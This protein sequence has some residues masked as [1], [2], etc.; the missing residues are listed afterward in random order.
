[1]TPR[2]R[3]TKDLVR[4]R[5]TH[6]A[7]YSPAAYARLV[8]AVVET[9]EL[10][11]RFGSTVALD[12]LTLTVEPGEVFGFLGPNGAGKTTTVRLLL[13]IIRATSGSVRVF[14]AD[15]WR[16]AVEIHRR[17]AYVPGEI[18]L[19][20][21]LTGAEILELLGSLHGGVDRNYRDELC[22]R[23]AL[24]PTKKSR[25]YSKGN[26]QKV[27][28]VA[29]LMTRADLLVLDEPTSGLDP[30]MEIAFREC[31]AEATARG[32]TVFLSSHILSEVE[33]LA[34]RV[35][36]LRSG[37]L[38]DLGTLAQLR[39]LRARRV[40]IRFDGAVPD[41]ALVPGVTTVARN[42]GT[43]DVEVQGSMAPL[44]Q[45]IAAY[46]VVGLDSREPSLEEIFVA[47]YGAERDSNAA[48]GSL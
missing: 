9:R 19:W 43:V 21:Q 15:A 30:L 39:H 1:M 48:N 24:D 36:I 5:P 46:D 20:P 29:A 47:D 32:Q 14:G 38:I 12:N 35:G 2:R 41:L 37:R 33:A 11:K 31:V 6:D 22:E 18:A 25:A 16:D 44:V 27:A 13:G 34:N 42:D 45:A 17:L 28:L 7:R 4:D 3:G 26:R 40:E 23:F 10:T 8:G